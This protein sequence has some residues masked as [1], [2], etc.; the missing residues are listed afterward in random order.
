MDLTW[1]L[2]EISDGE[3]CNYLKHYHAHYKSLR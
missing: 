2:K 1:Q 3:P